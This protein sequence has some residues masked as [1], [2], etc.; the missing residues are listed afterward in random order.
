MAEGRSY[1]VVLEWDQESKVWVVSVPALP[2]CFTQG[3]SEEEAMERA[4]DAIECHLAG[5]KADGL[6]IPQDVSVELGRVE[7]TV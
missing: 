2:G 1:R 3:A 5:L 6:P 4:K 7:V